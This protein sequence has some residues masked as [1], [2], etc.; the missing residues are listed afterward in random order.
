MDKRT[1]SPTF[2][3]GAC[4]SIRIT[5]EAP[6]TETS[7]VKCCDCGAYFAPWCLFVDELHWRLV[8][9]G[10]AYVQQSTVKH[11]KTLN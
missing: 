4:G 5:V 8:K 6:L 7:A 3:C 9:L 2:A 11:R 1:D 10:A